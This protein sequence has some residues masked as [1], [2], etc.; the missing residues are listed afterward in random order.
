MRRMLSREEFRLLHY[1]GEV[2]YNVTGFLDKNNDWLKQ[3]PEGDISRCVRRRGPTGT[4]HLVDGVSTL[5]T[6]LGYTAE[7]YK[8][9]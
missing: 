5:V 2:N 7:E 9:G 1:A 3:E 8:L 4:A 6:H